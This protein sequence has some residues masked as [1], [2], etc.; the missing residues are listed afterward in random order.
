MDTITLPAMLQ[1]LAVTVALGFFAVGLYSSIKDL[2]YSTNDPAEAEA[3]SR[4][5]FKKAVIMVACGIG[6]FAVARFASL[7]GQPDR[8]SIGAA[9]LQAVWEAVRDRGFLLLIPIGVRLWRKKSSK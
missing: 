7:L 3:H 9:A 2:S 8:Q 4:E 1:L 6:V 5:A